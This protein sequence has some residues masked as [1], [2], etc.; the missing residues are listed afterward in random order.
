MGKFTDI[1]VVDEPVYFM[2]SWDAR[3]GSCQSLLEF[4]ELTQ[5]GPLQV[6]KLVSLEFQH[7]G[8]FVDTR[9]EPAG[10]SSKLFDQKMSAAQV[11]G[12]EK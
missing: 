9:V 5:A 10:G 6:W 1:L 12:K 3:A 7:G 2:I 11:G 8:S 4:L